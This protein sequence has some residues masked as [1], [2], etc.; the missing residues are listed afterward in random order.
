[1][2]SAARDGD[3]VCRCTRLHKRY[4]KGWGRYT[5]IHKDV[6]EVGRL[7]GVYVRW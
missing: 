1:M 5:R 6:K 2:G 3:N 4:G 7:Q